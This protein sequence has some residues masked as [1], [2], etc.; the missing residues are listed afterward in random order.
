MRDNCQYFIH[1]FLLLMVLLTTGCASTEKLVDQKYVQGAYLST[2][3]TTPTEVRRETLVS[4]DNNRIQ[5]SEIIYFSR[6]DTQLYEKKLER[7]Y[8]RE[9]GSDFGD[10]AEATILTPLALVG[11]AILWGGLLVGEFM[12]WTTMTWDDVFDTNSRYITK[13]T[14]IP[15][16]YIKKSAYKQT[17][18]QVALSK[19]NIDVYLNKEKAITLRTDENG[20]AHYNTLELL[21]G[22][23]IHPKDLIHGQGLKVTA[24]VNNARNSITIPNSSIPDSYFSQKFRDLNAE[25]MARP[26]RLDNCQ[27]ISQA[28]RE[29]F[30]CF[31]QR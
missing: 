3:T 28:Y 6:H 26:S 31:Y 12:P 9:E 25:L 16:E 27:T 7:E 23:N 29:I 21:L 30:E 24:S 13:V 14:V 1:A 15:N 8:K 19:A 2:E 22:T 5:T 10:V 17:S 18:E 4:I 11:D 20:V